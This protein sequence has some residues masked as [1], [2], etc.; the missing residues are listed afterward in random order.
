[1][2]MKWIVYLLIVISVFAVTAC[3]QQGTQGTQ[4]FTESGEVIDQPLSADEVAKL[5]VAA[6]PTPIV[7]ATPGADV[8]ITYNKEK[9]ITVKYLDL[10]TN[11]IVSK[12]YKVA[13]DESNATAF[14]AL[15]EVYIKGVLKSNNIGVNS[16]V[17]S[18]GNV[19]VDFTDS[20]YNLNMGSNGEYAILEGIADTY[21]ENVEGIKGVYFTVNGGT[22]AS[23]H[24]ELMKDQP[25]KQKGDK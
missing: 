18:D 17:F 5:E 1:M 10:E 15:N 13:D 7:T 21:I 24:M 3:A 12:E 16:V 8:P 23:E 25:Y 6:T 11:E 2:K 20:I 19:F 4:K 14:D 9:S 22:Y